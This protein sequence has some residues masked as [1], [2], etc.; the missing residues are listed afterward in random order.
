MTMRQSIG[1]ASVLAAALLLLTQTAMAMGGRGG[2]ASVVISSVQFLDLAN[3]KTRIEILGGG[4]T[5]GAAPVVTCGVATPT[6]T[7]AA[8]SLRLADHLRDEIAP[9]A[10][11]AGADRR[12]PVRVSTLSGVR[13]RGSSNP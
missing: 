1:F 12:D 3:G 11:R 2:G 8:V 6:L 9:P 13:E 4:F 7:I 10:A 5:N